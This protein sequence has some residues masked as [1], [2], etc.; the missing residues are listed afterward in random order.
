M[1]PPCFIGKEV[2]LT[3]AAIG[4]YVSIGD[5]CTIENS[6]IKNSI[7]Y[8]HAFISNASLTDSIIGSYATVKGDALICNIGEYASVEGRKS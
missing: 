4:P 5:G 3:N 8:D 2:T 7:V 1:T 6:T